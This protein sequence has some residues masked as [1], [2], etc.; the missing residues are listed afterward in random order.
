MNHKFQNLIINK[1]LHRLAW[2]KSF[3]KTTNNV[4][5]ES[6]LKSVNSLNPC[7][8]FNMEIVIYFWNFASLYYSIYNYQSDH[9][10]KVFKASI[11]LPPL[12]S[13]AIASLLFH[14]FLICKNVTCLRANEWSN[15]RET[16]ILFCLLRGF[17]VDLPRLISHIW[18]SM[19]VSVWHS[20]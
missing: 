13:K 7:F 8:F 11:L 6:K 19:M 3:L 15:C 1:L 17:L 12:L 16:S 4:S 18:V 10:E 9:F 2:Y 5:F 14:F 20:Q